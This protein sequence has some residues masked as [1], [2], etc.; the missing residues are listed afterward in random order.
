[1]AASTGY[2]ACEEQRDPPEQGAS[3]E[4]R[5]NARFRKE[6]GDRGDEDDPPTRSGFERAAADKLSGGSARSRK[7]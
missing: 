7:D 5:D 2:G 6:I 1:M 3:S 4:D